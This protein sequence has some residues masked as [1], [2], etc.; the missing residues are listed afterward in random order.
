MNINNLSFLLKL[1]SC[2][3]KIHIKQF[4]TLNLLYIVNMYI[5]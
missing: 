1:N 4:E 2:D 3:I 5:Y